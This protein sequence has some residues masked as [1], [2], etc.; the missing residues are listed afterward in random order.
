L[1]VVSECREGGEREKE[2]LPPILCTC[3]SRLRDRRASWGGEVL[4]LRDG[5]R[6]RNKGGASS[7]RYRRRSF[8]SSHE[9]EPRG[10]ELI[11]ALIGTARVQ[12]KGRRKV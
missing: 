9:L 10:S 4:N 11:K 12:M 1:E 7:Y 3:V 6:D 5:E 8:K 2:D